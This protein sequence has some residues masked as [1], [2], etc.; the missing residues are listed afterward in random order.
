MLRESLQNACIGL[1]KEMRNLKS[2]KKLSIGIG[3]LKYEYSL[4]TKG[5]RQ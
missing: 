4:K 2:R 5:K 3:V 1:D